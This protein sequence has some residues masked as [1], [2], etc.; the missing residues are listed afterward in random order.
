MS[1]PI[2]IIFERHWDTIPKLLVKDALSDLSKRGYENLCFEVSHELSSLEIINRHDAGLK[3]D[4]DIQQQTEACLKK[5]NITAK[6][7]DISFTKLSQLMRLY[8]SSKKYHE[9]ATKIKQL[10]A[11]LILKEIFNDTT[12]LSMSVKGVDIA[13]FDDV[14]TGDISEVASKVRRDENFRIATIFKNLCKLRSQQKEGIVFI[15][16]AFHAEGLLNEFKKHNLEKEVLY[17]FP[18]STSRY[19]ESM[20]DIKEAMNKTLKD[21]TY[22]LSPKEIRPLKEKIIKEVVEKTNYEMQIQQGTMNSQFLSEIFKTNVR[23]FLRPGY[24]VDALVDAE[25]NSEGEMIE[26]RFSELG[27]K[28]HPLTLNDHKYLVIPNINTKDI[29]DRIHKIRL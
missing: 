8:V 25:R 15:C 14:V 23:A 18:H 5:L 3:F 11:S 9:V 4:S 19:D 21:H 13:D 2:V 6:L 27:V 24:H 28:T 16:G 1:L 17:Y 10:P 26:K 29:S 7:C 20:D 12:K 22:L